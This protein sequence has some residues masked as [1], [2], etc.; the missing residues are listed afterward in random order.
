MVGTFLS[1][2]SNELNW[3]RTTTLVVGAALV[4]MLSLFGTPLLLLPISRPRPV[5]R[6]VDAPRWRDIAMAVEDENGEALHRARVFFDQVREVGDRDDVERSPT[7]IVFD[8]SIYKNV[9][10]TLPLIV[11]AKD[12]DE[13]FKAR[14]HATIDISD[15]KINLG[16]ESV[17]RFIA[18]V[19]DT[20][21]VLNEAV[22]FEDI[23]DFAFVSRN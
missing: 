12:I 9:A 8:T 17:G 4:A 16:L 11:E 18:T 6:D 5:R 7:H 13:L 15:E 19:R 1:V 3:S 23:D 21:E 20:R 22:A 10:P 2:A 14:Q